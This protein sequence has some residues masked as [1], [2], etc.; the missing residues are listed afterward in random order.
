MPSLRTAR[1]VAAVCIALLT[2]PCLAQTPKP[3]YGIKEAE[4]RT[5]SA[6]KRYEVQ[7]S[8]IAINKRYN[9]LSIAERASLNQYYEKMEPGDE[10][11]FPSEGL[12]PIHEAIRK[13]QAKLLVTGELILLA[14]VGATGEVLE[15]KAIGSPSPEMTQFAAS[16]LFLTKFKPGLC[17]G[18]PCKM[19]FPF[20][21]NFRVQ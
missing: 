6:I 2:V 18:Q 7:G 15:I 11:P 8:P 17:Q 9:E 13:G 21:F 20:R 4:A 3:E 19:E 12:K 14:T 10:P 16:A 1:R 5:G